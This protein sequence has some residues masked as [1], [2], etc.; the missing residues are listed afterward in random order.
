MSQPLEQLIANSASFK[1]SKQRLI[2][3]LN[4]AELPRIMYADETLSIPVLRQVIAALQQQ[5]TTVL[6]LLKQHGDVVSLDAFMLHLLELWQ[7]VAPAWI[8]QAAARLGGGRVL[9]WLIARAQHQANYRSTIS[10]RVLCE[11]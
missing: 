11:A 8:L 4:L 5:D 2:K 3:D 1:L 9:A 7:N 6:M 10:I